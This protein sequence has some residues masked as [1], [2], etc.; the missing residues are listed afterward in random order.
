MEKILVIRIVFK[1]M[2]D[3][4][5][6]WEVY[7]EWGNLLRFCREYSISLKDIYRAKKELIDIRDFPTSA[8]E[9]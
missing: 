1:S 7:K 6:E 4:V 9:G 5:V 8:W 3:L 2:P